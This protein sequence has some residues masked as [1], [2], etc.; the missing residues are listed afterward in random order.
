MIHTRPDDYIIGAIKA[1]VRSVKS[2]G[3]AFARAL[4]GRGL[5]LRV[6]ARAR[7]RALKRAKRAAHPTLNA[8]LSAAGA[9]AVDERED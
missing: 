8:E 7:L 2:S 4:A 9:R 6:R 3:R 1:Y 5:S